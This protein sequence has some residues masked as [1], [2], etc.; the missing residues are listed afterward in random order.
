LLHISKQILH[1]HF[2]IGSELAAPKVEL[3]QMAVVWPTLLLK[4]KPE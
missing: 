4:K 1:G 2:H 3:A